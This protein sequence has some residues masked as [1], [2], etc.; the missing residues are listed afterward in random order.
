MALLLGNS[1]LPAVPSAVTAVVWDP[2]D[3]RLLVCY[4]SGGN[5]YVV[6]GSRSGG[7]VTF[8]TPVQVG[9][10]TGSAGQGAY[11]GGSKVVAALDNDVYVFTITPG[12]NSVAVSSAQTGGTSFRG[13]I[14][15]DGAGTVVMHDQWSGVVAGTVSGTTIT[16]GSNATGHFDPF[17][18]RGIIYDPASGKYV[19][20]GDDDQSFDSVCNILT[21]T[22][23]AITVGPL[24][25]LSSSWAADGYMLA[26]N[27]NDGKVMWGGRIDYSVDIR[28]FTVVGDDVTQD[29]AGVGY[30]V[31]GQS[32]FT[33]RRFGYDPATNKPFVYA[34]SG[35][36][37]PDTFIWGMSL[38]GSTFGY[39]TERYTPHP[40]IWREVQSTYFVL[41]GSV[42]IACGHFA[43]EHPSLTGAECVD[44]IDLAQDPVY[45]CATVSTQPASKIVDSNTSETH[46]VY[47]GDG[48]FVFG[49]GDPNN[50]GYS[51]VMLGRCD[52]SDGTLSFGVPVS[53]GDQE[54]LY[55][56]FTGGPTG[57]LVVSYTYQNRPCYRVLDVTLSTLTIDTVGPRRQVQNIWYTYN[58]T[59][60]VYDESTGKYVCIW[61][62]NDPN[63]KWEV[64]TLSGN[65]I[66]WNGLGNAF[67]SDNSFARPMVYALGDGRLALLS[68]GVSSPSGGNIAI[69][70]ISGLTL[71]IGS[72]YQLDDSSLSWPEVAYDADNGVLWVISEFLSKLD[73]GTSG[74]SIANVFTGHRVNWEYNG[75]RQQ[76]ALIGAKHVPV[77]G[78]Y[79]DS[80]Y[81]QYSLVTGPGNNSNVGI[82]FDSLPAV[83]GDPVKTSNANPDACH[84]F[85]GADS[86][87]GV[88][89][90]QY[91]S[92]ELYAQSFQSI[93]PVEPTYSCYVKPTKFDIV[94]PSTVGSPG[95]PGQP[96][97]PARTVQENCVTYTGGYEPAG[98]NQ[99]YEWECQEYE[100]S[101]SLVLGEQNDQ[102][103]STKTV[104]W[105]VKRPLPRGA[106]A[107]GKVHRYQKP[108][109]I[110]DTVYY[111]EQPY[112][113]PTPAA[114][115]TP[116]E[117]A[118][119]YDLGWNF[120]QLIGTGF[121]S[122]ISI[123]D[124]TVGFN[125]SGVAF[126]ICKVADTQYPGLGK[127]AV[128]A[129]FTTDQV[130]FYA[131]G[132]QVGGS[133]TRQAGDVFILQQAGSQ[134]LI[135][136]DGIELARA[137]NF[138][139]GR[140][141]I[142]GNIYKAGDK[143]CLSDSSPEFSLGNDDDALATGGA[144]I[145][146]PAIGLIAYEGDYGIANVDLPVPTVDAYEVL[147]GGADITLTPIYVFAAEGTTGFA[148]IQLPA[149]TL[150][151][152]SYEQFNGYADVTLPAPQAFGADAPRAEGNVVLPVPEVYGEAQG[153]T[154]TTQGADIRLPY[155]GG[156]GFSW[157]G[158]VGGV[159]QT[160]PAIDGYGADR[161][162]YGEARITLP[163]ITV[164]AFDQ[165]K[166]GNILYGEFENLDV[167]D[168]Y[169]YMGNPNGLDGSL[170]RLEAEIYCGANL[171]V[172]IPFDGD[173][174]ATIANVARF[175]LTFERMQLNSTGLTGGAGT[176][177]AQLTLFLDGEFWGG[178]KLDGRLPEMSGDLT[179]VV[180]SV[181]V[182][183]GEFAPMTA[184]IRA[185]RGE[186]ST[187]VGDLPGL[188]ALWG[189]LDG[190][191]EGLTGEFVE[192]TSQ[193]TDYVAWVMNMQHKG[194]TRYPDYPFQFVVRSNG[195]NF[196][197]KADGV[198]ELEGDRD[199]EANIL[200]GFTLPP[201]DYG[202]DT[203]KRAPRFYLKGNL[204]EQFRVSVQADEEEEWH[205]ASVIDRGVGYMRCKLPRGVKGTYLGFDVENF[206]G[207]DFEVEQ[208][209]V[210]I[211]DTGRKV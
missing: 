10:G 81:D 79:I 18:N 168:F 128:Y 96:Y 64:G 22:G 206:D 121:N 159:E 34:S 30:G 13:E 2:D 132:Q 173:F 165:E 112:I 45:N 167:E 25:T 119:S 88:V 23:T 101:E 190:T 135:T 144:D 154:I 126:G 72:W 130:R 26:I 27:G 137:D 111:P 109:T 193:A 152:G 129:L 14:V 6:V 116:A 37:Y 197:V 148:F 166:F 107:F 57:K 20:L 68:T 171:D 134:A 42:M 204:E 106:L 66:T 86:E 174:T 84:V 194:L 93:D 67:I 153:F 32:T 163:A 162:S 80:T 195:K 90:T 59:A 161:A 94:R 95:H 98:L 31:T 12:D 51:T 180:S 63:T 87:W 9:S 62:Q 56:V 178:A 186:F 82:C 199:L 179:G 147:T 155:I 4:E 120:D 69:A 61:A 188:E 177:D 47:L 78:H 15:S 58:G 48:Y 211:N 100:Y 187:L 29:P 92:D 105:L 41:D 207:R 60:V 35:G 160:L 17:N 198:Y 143:F 136:K 113:A 203:I 44:V 176:A 8:G 33:R 201:S 133:L 189:F 146:L 164:F 53:L 110:C 183:D 184:D 104:C 139:D 97:M 185:S 85:G 49:Y 209:S 75:N 38:T 74:N 43:N 65:A 157:T 76:F 77:T 55:P 169:A 103:L 7:T 127:F 125:T 202:I 89:L 46:P 115:P 1:S 141:A 11:I 28:Q 50:S 118:I 108:V 138:T 208:A 122:K 70:T 102:Q 142:M 3:A 117:Y 175:D 151:G 145:T 205:N 5:S 150:Q 172:E 39:F 54:W 52:P 21:V 24:R 191:M 192:T 19:L 40:H 73:I 182:L 200:A 196:V 36:T 149:P 16:W 83:T 140:T 156:G 114:A 123:T 91:S 71:S 124:T 170:G 210:L 131:N 99:T 158:E 181:G